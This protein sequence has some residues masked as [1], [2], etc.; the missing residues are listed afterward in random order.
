VAVFQWHG[1]D[2]RGR[3]VKGIRDADNA[4]LLRAMLRKEGV[5]AT[6]I[7]EEGLA[8]TRTR[9]ELDF[10]QYF[11][12]IS[13]GQVALITRQLATLLRSGVP[14]VESLSAMIEQVDHLKL[15]AALT[16]TRDKHAQGVSHVLPPRAPQQVEPRWRDA[17]TV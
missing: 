12:R 17:S 14:L 10:G 4:R 2:A 3:D 15:R 1:I 9:R 13:I 16:Q 7:E 5:L 6:A 11:Q 8:R